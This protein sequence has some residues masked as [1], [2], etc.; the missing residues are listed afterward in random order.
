MI[1]IFTLIYCLA[2]W[3]LFAKLKVVKVSPT[4][5]AAAAVV[6][7]VF[8]GGIII[9]WS[10]GAP[11]TNQMV[12]TRYAVQIVPQV[13][14]QVK[15]IHAEPLQPM[16]KGDLLFEI[17][18][19]PFQ[20]SVDQ[21]TAQLA[22]AQQTVKQSQAGLK[23]A[24]ASIKQSTANLEA[25][26]TALEISSATEKLNSNAISKLK[27][28][29]LEQS[30]VAAEAAVEQAEA[31]LEQAEFALKGAEDSRRAVEAQL[32]N[33]KFNLEQCT[34]RAP[35]D[36]FVVNWQLREG[37][38]ASSIPLAAVGTFVETDDVFLVAS[39]NQN[40]VT[41]VEPGNLVDIALRSRPGVVVTGKVEAVIP[42]TGEGQFVTGGKLISAADIASNGKYAVK[43]SLDD[44][45]SVKDLEMGTPGFVAIYTDR[46]KPF[47]IISKVVTRMNAWQYYL[48][49]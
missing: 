9:L 5:I 39:F 8:I 29:Q 36:G 38:M 42:T 19:D 6:G 40:V 43:I 21:L 32:G 47:H 18:P 28:V 17:L 16:K 35:T 41:F 7:V 46:F 15:Q 22:A 13:K 37:T 30:F 10:F 24:K 2:V 12:V 44:P 11:N 4:S 27:V 48:L 45:Q 49:P 26:K 1:A 14:G 3:L 33:A 34:V 25:A 20:Y 31:G 23:V